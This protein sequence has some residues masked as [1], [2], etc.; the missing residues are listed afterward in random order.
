MREESCRTD[1]VGAA[2]ADAADAA[3]QRSDS[4]D[5]GVEH[6]NQCRRIA[7]VHVAGAIVGDA[8]DVLKGG[9]GGRAVSMPSRARACRR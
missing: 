6:A 3:R 5:G 8:V 7:H 2:R 4:A 9:G 1:T